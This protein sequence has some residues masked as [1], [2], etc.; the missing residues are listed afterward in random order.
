MQT[1]V[2]FRCPLL[3]CEHLEFGRY[4]IGSL[5]RPDQPSEARTET[6]RKLRSC[7]DLLSLA[8]QLFDLHAPARRLER[9]A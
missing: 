4:S 6:Q 5:L 9:L 8:L 3:H 2:D 1:L 7:H